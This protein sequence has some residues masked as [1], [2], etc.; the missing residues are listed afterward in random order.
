MVKQKTFFKRLTK[1]ILFLFIFLGIG[2]IALYFALKSP[3]VQTYIAQKITDNLSENIGL[4]IHVGAIDVSFFNELSIQD[5]S[6]LDNE[7]DTIAYVQDLNARFDYFSL[8]Q[9]KV[10]LNKLVI[11]EVYVNI[12]RAYED[13]L[14]KLDYATLNNQATNDNT[15]KTS[16]KKPWQFSISEAQINSLKVNY[17][18]YYGGTIVKNE[19]SQLELVF[20]YFNLGDANI[21]L[22]HL[23][24]NQPTTIIEKQAANPAFEKVK[25][26]SIHFYI[27]FYI[28]S[29]SLAINDGQFKLINH[30]TQNTSKAKFQAND[31][32]W[33]KIQLDV[34]DFILNYDSIYASIDNI[35]AIEKSGLTIKHLKNQASFTNEGINIEN[36]YLTTNYSEVASDIALSYENLSSF[37]R[38]SNDIRM[39]IQLNHAEIHPNDLKLFTNSPQQAFAYP[40]YLNGHIYGS[41][42]N[43][44]GKNLSVRTIGKSIFEGN[45]SLN[46]LPEIDQ[47]F[48]SG[49]V[50]RLQTSYADIKRFKPS[51]K[52]P[53]NFEKLGNL[54]FTGRFDGFVKDFVMYGSLSTSL[55]SAETDLNFKIDDQQNASYSGSFALNNFDIGNY[56][57]LENQLGKISLQGK[58]EGK[59]VKLNTLDISIDATVDSFMVNNY[60]YKNIIVNGRV[61]DNFFKGDL[62]IEDDNIHIDFNGEVDATQEI[63]HFA[64]SAEVKEIDLKALNLWNKDWLLSGQIESNFSAST[65]NNVNG[66]IEF[67]NV[68]VKT[69]NQT[70]DVGNIALVGQPLSGGQRRIIL[71]SKDIVAN[72][73]GKFQFEHLIEASKS[74][75]FPNYETEAPQQIVRYDLQINNDPELLN[76]LLPDL[77]VLKPSTLNGNLNSGTKQLL[78]IANI[79][80]LQYQNFSILDI[81]SS[82][83]IEEG[84]FDVIQSVPEVYLK[85]SLFIKDFSF[86]ANGTKDDLAIKLFADGAQSSSIELL[87][88]LSEYNNGVKLVFEPSNIF[89]NNQFW[90]IDEDNEVVLGK[91][92]SSKNLKLYNGISELIVDVEIAKSEQKT[93]VFL[94]NIFIEDF[95][96]FLEA[97][98]INLKGIANGKV[99]I[100]NVDNESSFYGDLMIENIQVNNYNIG[101]LNSSATLDLPNKR[102]QINGNLYG[103]DNEVDIN[104]TYSFAKESTNKDIDLNFDIKNFAIYTIED[105]IAEYIDNTKGTVSGQLSV[106][107]PKAKPELIGYVDVT[108]VTTTVTYLQTTYNIENERVNFEKGAINLGSHLKVT[109]ME[110]NVAYGKG[111]IL[112]NNLKDITLDI[113]V[114]SDKI[115]GL[116]TTYSDNQ[117]FYGTAYLNGKAFFKGLTTDVAISI[118]GESEGD[119]E[120]AIP[121]MESGQVN[122]NEFY[123]FVVK[124]K[125]EEK[126]FLIE[127]EEKFK[128]NGLT[129]NLDLDI[130]NDCKV[131]IILDQ[132]TGDVL[133][134]KG[135]GN[136]NINVPKEGDVMFYGNYVISNGD[137]LFTLQS[138]INKK[139]KIEPN[140]FINFQGRIEDTQV[141]VDAIYNLR[142]A[143]EN[144]ISDFLEN[145]EEQ[146]QSEARN[147]VPVKLLLN[148][149]N[150]LYNP[151]ITFD[152]EIDQLTPV[153]RNYVDRKMFTLKQY[154]NEMNRQVFGLLVLNQFLPPLSNLD[155]VTGGFN[156]SA[157][158]AANTMSE[159]LSN[160]L[161][162]YFNDWLSYL[163][164]DV[165]LN[166]N[167]RNYEQDGTTSIEDINLRREL[168]LALTTRFL[169]DRVIINLGG[170]VDFGTNQLGTDNTNTTYFGGNASIEY[171]LTQN[172][173]FRIKAFTTTDYDYFIQNNVTRAGVG[174]SFKREFD[175]LKDLKILKSEFK[176]K[177]T[178]VDT[179][180]NP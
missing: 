152:I 97:K 137:Y 148:L 56:F 55:G 135:E 59:G 58:G 143:P 104:G 164:D 12:T 105:F 63:P 180:E 128:V 8:F 43:V 64:F 36:L 140:S 25:K 88:N 168:Q 142:A 100:N 110:G 79:P 39:D 38:F 15:T 71:N 18:D 169:N 42:S 107:G 52:L 65:I 82:V 117:D 78:A 136:I 93:D 83:F 81:S 40:V 6:V 99:S 123:S 57:G 102:V 132:T 176:I 34:S 177:T 7:N 28:E 13:S 131:K 170:N 46:G 44:K 120:I 10:S 35:N 109:D 160:Q 94:S 72:I 68:Q 144:L 166:F 89:I 85:D 115:M 158:D 178:P 54:F 23:Y 157:N 126:P 112:H 11:N 96:K 111:R 41:V 26:D 14:F 2:F 29:D 106:K 155:Q 147:R 74:V 75:L 53:P 92:I 21:E 153:I 173:R 62:A 118:V 114:E 84:N 165:S 119:T 76:L 103:D 130:D 171:A 37:Q 95:T 47:T 33:Q 121:L 27:P 80:I 122:Q 167:Y 98:D 49:S 87:A 124:E 113:E 4:P 149:Q 91:R 3:K 163:S 51:L 139:F 108:D 151:D 138:V 145:V 150:S 154:E 129:V 162:R 116:N 19:L 159:F 77:K 172:R 1:I 156:F 73:E 86:L 133:E 17:L 45:V 22:N 70:Y 127:S 20:S 60:L 161:T 5:F 31:L 134:V 50:D 90:L 24:A 32:D 69:P 174:L 175:K 48:I 179:I 67:E 66:E 101:N 61:K 30:L 9:K 141:N 146:V 16:S 125:K